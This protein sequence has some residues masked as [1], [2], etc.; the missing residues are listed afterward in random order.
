M[1]LF[2]CAVYFIS[3]EIGAH[4]R[5]EAVLVRKMMVQDFTDLL[6][7]YPS[8]QYLLRQW[9]VDIMPLIFDSEITVVE[10]VLEVKVLFILFA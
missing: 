6:L 2:H 5:D 7:E 1:F 10:K 3:Q 8:H 4:C 9:T